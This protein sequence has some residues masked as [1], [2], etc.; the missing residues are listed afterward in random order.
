MPTTKQCPTCD[1]TLDTSA[2]ACPKCGRRFA[3]KLPSISMI[4]RRPWALPIM[5]GLAAA[6]VLTLGCWAATTMVSDANDRLAEMI[7]R[8]DKFLELHR[9]LQKHLQ[10]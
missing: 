3:I 1:W 5:T 10:R 2:K 4:L 7:A 9:E 8:G 6:I